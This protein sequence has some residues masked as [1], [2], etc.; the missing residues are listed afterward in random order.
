MRKIVFLFAGMLSLAASI[1]SQDASLPGNVTRSWRLA[2]GM[3]VI[4][5]RDVSSAT[6]VI[7][8]FIRGGKRAEPEEQLGLADLTCRLILQIQDEGDLRG[9]MGMGSTLAFQTE[10]DFLQVI[11]EDLSDNI[12][13]SLKIVGRMISSPLIN[14]VRISSLKEHMAFLRKTEDDDPAE[15]M[16]LAA[17]TAFFGPGG[18]GGSQ[19]GSDESM[20]KIRKKEVTAY[21]ERCF[22]GANMILSIVSDRDSA[23]LRPILDDV[24]GRFPSGVLEKPAEFVCRPP[25]KKALSLKKERIQSHISFAYALPGFTSKNFLS[26]LLLETCLGKGINSRLWRLREES[27]LAYDIHA[28]VT[29]M[30]S[31]GIIAVHLKTASDRKQEAIT[32]LNKILQ[33]IHERGIGEAEW[34]T[35]KRYTRGDFLRDIESKRKRGFFLGFFELMGIG[36]PFLDSLVRGT[37]SVTREEMNGYIHRV[38]SPENRIEVIIG[39]GETGIR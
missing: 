2:N 26:G 33:E 10:G 21:F 7:H 31:A 18:Y 15:R 4:H 37:E 36:Y 12:G 9:L 35:T 8:I 28:R 16:D 24:F 11:L 13:K 5:Q 32:E 39:P 17:R 34:E 38:L 6:S 20:E 19:F 29:P 1:V 14:G 30:L 22:T 25:D 3:T 23:E 27:N